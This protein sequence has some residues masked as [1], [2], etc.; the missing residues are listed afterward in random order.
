[1]KQKDMGLIYVTIDII[2]SEDIGLARRG[3]I[4]VDEIKR[5]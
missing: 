4:D 1:M 3:I 5:M 2:N